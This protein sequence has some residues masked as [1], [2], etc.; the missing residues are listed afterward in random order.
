MNTNL[1]VNA[2]QARGLLKAVRYSRMLGDA[3]RSVDAPNSLP[4]DD[5]LRGLETMLLA[6]LERLRDQEQRRTQGRWS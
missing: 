5:E 3:Y 1:H 4:S 2:R 6:A